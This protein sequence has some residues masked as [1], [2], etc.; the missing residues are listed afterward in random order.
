M[1]CYQKKNLLAEKVGFNTVGF[2]KVIVSLQKLQ[3]GQY[4]CFFGH[5][6]MFVSL[7]WLDHSKNTW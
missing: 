5:H 4:P 1:L 3:I 7:I 6:I 2:E